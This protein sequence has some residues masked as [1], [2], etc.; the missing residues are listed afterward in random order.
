MEIENDYVYSIKMF[1]ESGKD[2]ERKAIVPLKD[3]VEV[4]KMYDKINDSFN[5]MSVDLKKAVLIK[6]LEE[7]TNE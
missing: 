3:N 2:I 1:N 7:E 5:G 6:L 4:Q